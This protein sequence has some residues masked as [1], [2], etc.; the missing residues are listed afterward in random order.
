MKY[1]D[2]DIINYLKKI[3][4][5]ILLEYVLEVLEVGNLLLFICNFEKEVIVF[6]IL[7]WVK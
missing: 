4:Y 2:D 3:S 6:S 1:L 7:F 5:Y